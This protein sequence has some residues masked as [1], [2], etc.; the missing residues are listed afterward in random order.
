MKP[1]SHKELRKDVAE[2]MNLN[3]EFVDDVV[4]AYYEKLRKS[5]SNLEFPNI[6]VDKLCTFKV[7]ENRV[8]KAIKKSLDILGNLDKNTYSGIEKTMG[9]KEKLDQYNKI[10]EELKTIREA[11]EEFKSNKNV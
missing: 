11:K 9:V 10:K 6:Y 8:D 2:E 7:R 5:L 3:L 4:T 1:I